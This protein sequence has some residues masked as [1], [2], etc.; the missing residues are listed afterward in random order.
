M[1][2]D[3]I[4]PNI[5]VSKQ[6]IHFL[7]EMKN[8]FPSFINIVETT[9][10]KGKD[11]LKQHFNSII[12][13][14]GEGVMLRNPQSLYIAGRSENMKKYKAFFDTEVKVLKNHYPH[15]FDCVQ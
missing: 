15:G 2:V 8:S 12:T 7:K 13:K 3:Y 9:I 6:R 4:L 5:N 10:C 14:G 11:H 1:Y